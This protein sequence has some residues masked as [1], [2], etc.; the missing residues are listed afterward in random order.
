[1]ASRYL[2]NIGLA[3]AHGLLL[4]G[5]NHKYVYQVS[6]NEL[7]HIFEAFIHLRAISQEI[8][9]KTPWCGTIPRGPAKAN[10]D[11]LQYISVASISRTKS[12]DSFSFTLNVRGLSYLGLTRSISWLLMPW[13]LASPGHQQPWYWSS[14][15]KQVSPGLIRGRISTIYGISVKRNY[16]K[17]KYM[18]MFPLKNLARKELRITNQWQP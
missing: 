8:M 5:P 3:S 18:F 11:R 13:L 15:V 12:K 16:I 17:C 4:M 14:Y 9:I 10:R 1:M 2:V 7:L 6:I